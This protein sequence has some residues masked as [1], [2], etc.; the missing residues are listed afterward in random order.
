LPG[1]TPEQ[2]RK[3]LAKPEKTKSAKGKTIDT[4][5]RDVLTWFALTHKLFDEEKQESF[6]CANPNCQ[7]PR[8][9]TT[10]NAVV[11]LVNGQYICRYCFLSGYLLVIEGQ[12]KLNV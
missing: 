7:D 5:R 1:L 4:S 6:K 12:E 2:I 10:K 11:A 3:L 8:P 9:S